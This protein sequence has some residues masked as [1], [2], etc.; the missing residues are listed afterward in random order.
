[1]ETALR[2]LNNEWKFKDPS[3]RYWKMIPPRRHFE[4]TD[5]FVLANPKD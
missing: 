4:K 5:D 2:V 3:N 1:M